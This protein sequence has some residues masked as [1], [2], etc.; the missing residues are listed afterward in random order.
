MEARQSAVAQMPAT[1]APAR[2][3][4]APQPAPIDIEPFVD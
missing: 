1:P 3:T 4:S 2:E